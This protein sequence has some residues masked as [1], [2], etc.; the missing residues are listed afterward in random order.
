M[1]AKKRYEWF[2]FSIR[3]KIANNRVKIRHHVP[4]VENIPKLIVDAFTRVLYEDD[5][6][7]FVREV[8][9]E[10]ELLDDEK[11]VEILCYEN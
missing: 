9:V 8:Q 1:D 11:V 10:A 2:F 3:C 5:N 6:I 4:D 7:H